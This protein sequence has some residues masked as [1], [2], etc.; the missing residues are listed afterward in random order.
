M[1]DPV[2]DSSVIIDMFDTE[3]TRHELGKEFGDFL[4]EHKLKAYLPWTAM[5]EFNRAIVRI[6]IQKPPHQLSDHFNENHMLILERVPVGRAFFH[7]YFISRH[8]LVFGRSNVRDIKH[9]PKTF[10]KLN[11]GGTAVSSKQLFTRPRCFPNLAFIS[12]E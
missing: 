8:K 9:S 3:S 6:R 4:I 7:R 10:S 12:L 5:F 2:V 11:R 1:I